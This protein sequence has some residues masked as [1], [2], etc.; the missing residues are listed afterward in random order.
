MNREIIYDIRR[1]M[2]KK[3]LT[4]DL[5]QVIEKEDELI[6]Y[7]NSKKIKC[8]N[9]SYKI[10]CAGN[11]INKAIAR[12]FNLDKPICYVFDGINLKK[13]STRIC[14]GGG[15]K[16]IIRNCN[17]ELL[18][19]ISVNNNC[20]IDNTTIQSVGYVSIGARELVIKNMSSEQI[21][22]F[23]SKDFGFGAWDKLDIINCSIDNKD[24]KISFV[25]T[26]E[27]NIIGSKIS[28]NE[29]VCE[30]KSINVDKKS[31]LSAQ[32][33]VSITTDRIGETN[34]DAPTIVLNGT[35]ISNKNRP[36]VLN[37]LTLKRLQ[38]VQV[39]K[40]L[41]EKCDAINNKKVEN[42]DQKL[43]STDIG[44]VLKK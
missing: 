20:T 19:S 28:G 40:G 21:K 35:E 6:C 27:L 43:K 29:V 8:K 13:H 23:C 9:G 44:K 7:V 39:L 5:G 4:N 42:Y 1:E 3:I 41:K 26:N 30:A 32:E 31:S 22:V 11:E 10:F 24:S 25:A 36:F 34:I 33:K 15:C 37:E 18:N 38:L 16:V 17:F 2:A 14:G 12:E